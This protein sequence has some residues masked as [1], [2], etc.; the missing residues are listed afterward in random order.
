M[1][2]KR[3]ILIDGF[4]L[5]YRAFY[6]NKFMSTTDGRPT[7]ALFGFLG[8]VLRVM[9]DK[10]PDAV[11]VA[12]DAPGKT[13]RHAEFPEYKGTRR[14]MPDEMKSQI[15]IARELLISA[16]GIPQI[17]LVGYEA[18]DIIGTISR[19][20]E[21]HGYLTTIITGDHDALQ[22]VDHC[23]SVVTPKV[24][25]TDV[26]EYDVAAVIA[27]YGFGPEFLTDYK[28]MAGDSS[29]NIP[30]VPGIGDKVR[31][32]ADPKVWTRRGNAGAL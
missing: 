12:L 24:G 14:E 15:P 21:E 17:E 9:E 26:N 1:S 30:G 3:L 13:F 31:N 11:L 4:S 18:D 29:D 32:R 23:V 5:L 8:M 7:N 27:K 19:Q 16:L 25:V 28:A 22:L 20:A 10:K 2:T 6:G